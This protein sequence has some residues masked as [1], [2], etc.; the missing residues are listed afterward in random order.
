MTFPLKFSMTHLNEEN[1]DVN[2]SILTVFLFLRVFTSPQGGGED[3]GVE[4][5][6]QDEYCYLS[7][8]NPP[9]FSV[10]SSGVEYVLR[11]GYIGKLW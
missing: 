4:L 7:F 9:E 11:P 6:S 8:W 10:L 3:K 5:R 1:Q 2:R